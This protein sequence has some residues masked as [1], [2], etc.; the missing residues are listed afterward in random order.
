MVLIGAYLQK[1]LQVH[2]YT[3]HLHS[4]EGKPLIVL[5]DPKFIWALKAIEIHGIALLDG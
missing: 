5:L 4:F 3:N 1:W 2:S